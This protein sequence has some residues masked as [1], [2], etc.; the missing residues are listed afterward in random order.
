MS[1]DIISMSKSPEYTIYVYLKLNKV[2]LHMFMVC[3]CGTNYIS[4]VQC[5]LT[6]HR[7][8]HQKS[9]LYLFFIF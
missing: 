9:E 1:T 8:Y 7:T 6:F 2:Q 4:T 3:M 5:V